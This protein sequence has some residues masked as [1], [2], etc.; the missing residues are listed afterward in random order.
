MADASRANPPATSLNSVSSRGAVVLRPQLAWMEQFVLISLIPSQNNV[1][2]SIH[3]LNN[4]HRFLSSSPLTTAKPVPPAGLR[5]SYPN[6][7]FLRASLNSRAS[8]FAIFLQTISAAARSSGRAFGVFSPPEPL[9]KKISC[10][11]HFVVTIGCRK[12]GSLSSP[13]LSWA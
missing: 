3:L 11:F 5:P 9:K 7:T 8:V 10:P 6:V 13:T 1:C 4:D 12:R 2:S